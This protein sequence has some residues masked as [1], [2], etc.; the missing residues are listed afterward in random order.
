MG[1]TATG[2]QIVDKIHNYKIPKTK[3][4]TGN[5][6]DDDEGLHSKGNH[7]LEKAPNIKEKHLEVAIK[8]LQH[9]RTARLIGLIAHL[10]YWS[11][12]GHYN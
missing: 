4:P 8:E 10:A 3:R 1:A 5:G 7:A 6:D 9:E 11:V 12:F 2:T